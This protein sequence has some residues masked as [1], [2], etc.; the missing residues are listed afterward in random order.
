MEKNYLEL[1]VG[2]IV[3]AASLLFVTHIYA[4]RVGL[5]FSTQKHS[6]AAKF[7]NVEGISVGSPVKI[8]GVKIGEVSDINLDKEFFLVTVNIKIQSDIKIPKDSSIMVASSGIFGGKYL[9]IKPGNQDDFIKED[10]FFASTQSSLNL[11]GLIS[12]FAS[13]GNSGP[14]NQSSKAN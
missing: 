4:I 13:G 1:T 10:G 3:L 8:G 9:E 7:N 5:G 12:K 11:E 6:Y 2:S 14:Q